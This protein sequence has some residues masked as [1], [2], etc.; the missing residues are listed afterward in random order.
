MRLRYEV[1]FPTPE[2]PPDAPPY[3]SG[4]PKERSMERL[5]V[6]DY[7]RTMKSLLEKGR[8][9]LLRD[10]SVKWSRRGGRMVAV[11]V[12]EPRDGHDKAWDRF[13]G[14][15]KWADAIPSVEGVLKLLW[16]ELRWLLREGSD[17]VPPLVDVTVKVRPAAELRGARQR[18]RG[19][20]Q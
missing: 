19:G 13:R 10:G 3:K 4:E 11:Y 8:A 2:R 14:R 16:C 5:R 17:E 15:D 18:L 1:S 12:W 6:R 9:Y 20:E 7:D